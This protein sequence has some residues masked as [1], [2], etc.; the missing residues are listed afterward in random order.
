MELSLYFLACDSM[1]GLARKLVQTRQHLIFPLV[2]HLITFTLTL[3]MGTTSVKSFFSTMNIV[4]TDF[5][6]KIDDGWLNNLIIC[7]VEKKYLQKVM[8]TSLSYVFML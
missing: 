2:Y 1:S 4:K 6:N 3:P 5:R 7:Y 8:T